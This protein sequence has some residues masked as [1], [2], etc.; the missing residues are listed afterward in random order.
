LDPTAASQH[1]EHAGEDLEPQ[2]LFIPEAV[3]ATLED[4]DLVVQSL[5]EPEGTLFSARQ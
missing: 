2:V 3:G 5:D 1:R 4:A